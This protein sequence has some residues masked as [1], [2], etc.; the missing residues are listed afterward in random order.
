MLTVKVKLNSIDRVKAF[1][2]IMTKQPFDVDI[3][4]DRYVINAKSIMGIFS[5]NLIE[6]KELRAFVDTD[7]A[8]ETFKKEISEFIV[9]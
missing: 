2:N 9:E 5:L 4:S 3:I 1:V 6:P 7:K 8:A